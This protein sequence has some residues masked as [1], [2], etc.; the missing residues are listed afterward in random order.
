MFSSMTAGAALLVHT[1]LLRGAV[2]AERAGPDDEAHSAGANLG[3]EGHLHPGLGTQGQRP[4]QMQV[5]QTRVGH[6]SIL[7][8]PT[9]PDPTQY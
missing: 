4:L 5:R 6:G 7:C 2:V 9:Q 3:G 1:G 8:D